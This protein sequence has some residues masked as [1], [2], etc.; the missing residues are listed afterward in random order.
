MQSHQ[1][2][3]CSRRSDSRA[4]RK[5]DEEK[6]VSLR[7][8]LHFPHVRFT[9]SPPYL[10][11]ALYYL[12]AWNRLISL[13]K[14]DYVNSQTLYSYR[15]D[16]RPTG[17]LHY[18]EHTGRA[19]STSQLCLSCPILIRLRAVSLF[20]C[21]PSSALPLLKQIWRKRETARSLHPD[22]LVETVVNLRKRTTGEISRRQILRDKH[23][24]NFVWKIF[25]PNLT[26]L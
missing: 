10:N 18:L 7:F 15:W 19:L 24:N 20:F 25:P 12:N 5:I 26:V 21:S 4:G 17:F 6:K 8:S 23:D 1:F 16:R 11:F 22:A 9:R 13:R 3:A 14:V 2:V